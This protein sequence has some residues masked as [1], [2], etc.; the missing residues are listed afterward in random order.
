[1]AAAAAMD[2]RY[3]AFSNLSS[4]QEDI[5]NSLPTEIDCVHRARIELKSG[6]A[7]CQINQQFSLGPF[8]QRGKISV[9]S[10]FRTNLGSDRK[11]R[12][13]DLAKA[14]RLP[15]E[16]ERAHRE[17]SEKGLSAEELLKLIGIWTC[18]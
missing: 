2:Q 11:G 12:D 9:V 1:M 14:S 16:Q 3:A 10:A 18:L 15:L 4:S 8:P 13:K 7:N 6:G 17:S 5:Q